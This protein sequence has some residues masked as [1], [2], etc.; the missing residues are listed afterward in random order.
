[1]EDGN[2]GVTPI[3]KDNKTKWKGCTVEGSVFLGKGIRQNNTEK[4]CIQ[5]CGLPIGK[6]V[7]TPLKRSMVYNPLPTNYCMG[8]IKSIKDL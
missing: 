1:M 7:L 3:H 6:T 4:P 8:E 5:R 2:A